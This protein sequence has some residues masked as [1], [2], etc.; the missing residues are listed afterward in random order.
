M[1]VQGSDTSDMLEWARVLDRHVEIHGGTIRLFAFHTGPLSN[2]DDSSCAAVASLMKR[3]SSVELVR[4]AG[5]SGFMEALSGCRAILTA[6]LHGAILGLIA[7][8]TPV[9]VPYS[10]KSPR[11]M[12]EAGLEEFVVDRSGGRWADDAGAR[13]DRAWRNPG[14]IWRTLE[15]RRAELASRASLNS[16][17]FKGMALDVLR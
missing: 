13:L 1:K 11:F 9:A 5:L 14:D 2:S 3:S 4:A 12:K 7:G 6:P 8:A 17:L 10:S 15:D 16:A